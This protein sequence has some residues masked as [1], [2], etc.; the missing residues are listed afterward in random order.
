MK[1]SSASNKEIKTIYPTKNDVDLALQASELI[2]I[3]AE[4]G[5]MLEQSPEQL[6]QMAAQGML[7]LLINEEE[8]VIGTS[9][10]TFQW[11]GGFVEFG[12]WTVADDYQ[13]MGLGSKVAKELLA[14]A[15]IS[16]GK[17][18][19]AFAN[20]DSK[21]PFLKWGG[22]VLDQR[23]MHPDAFIPCQTCHCEGKEH[24]NN[25]QKCVDTIIDL[26]PVVRKLKKEKKQEERRNR[27][28]Q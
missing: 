11:P 28:K 7:A 26:T 17:K 5:L 13:E 25:G 10:M 23:R 3:A 18:I 8:K 12:A 15:D 24:L 1:V 6:L 20:K 27:A 19:I 4:R 14:L 22:K 21:K 9:A 2:R 16:K